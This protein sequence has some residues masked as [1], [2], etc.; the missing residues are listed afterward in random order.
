MHAVQKT[1][2]NGG[3]ADGALAETARLILC[4]PAQTGN[5]VAARM[6]SFT[7]LAKA[8]R[9]LVARMTFAAERGQGARLT[10]SL[11]AGPGIADL[12]AEA[13]GVAVP[14]AMRALGTHVLRARAP[15]GDQ[16]TIG[17][18]RRLGMQSYGRVASAGS[19]AA[20]VRFEKDLCGIM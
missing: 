10:L 12:M 8:D 15:I 19:A 2:Q 4:R 16:A 5:P 6:L 17:V 9:R 11:G 1:H 7:V 18:L 13:A 3:D 14:M 20:I